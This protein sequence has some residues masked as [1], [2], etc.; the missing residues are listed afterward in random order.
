MEQVKSTYGAN[1]KLSKSVYHILLTCLTVTDSVDD[2][3]VEEEAE[4]T[5][6]SFSASYQVYV[7]AYYGYHYHQVDVSLTMVIIIVLLLICL[8]SSSST[9]DLFPSSSVSDM[10]VLLM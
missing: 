4:N 6:L 3:L 5:Q 2:R 8:L 1:D 7:T 10:V 9:T